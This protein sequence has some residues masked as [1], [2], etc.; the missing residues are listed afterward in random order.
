M[1]A[2]DV[3]RLIEIAKYSLIDIEDPVNIVPVCLILFCLV[4]SGRPR[5]FLSFWAMFNACI[6]HCWMDG[7]IGIFARGP[8]WL[9]EQY[10][11]LDMRYWLTRDPMVMMISAV[12]LVIMGP[13][14]LIWYH[15]L[16]Q[17]RWYSDVV[18]II[19]STFQLMGTILYV[20]G[21]VL[22]NFVH[23]PSD[24]PP[25]F[26]KTKDLFYFWFVFVFCNSVWIFLPITI[27][28]KSFWNIS[29]IYHQQVKQSKPG[30]KKKKASKQD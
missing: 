18:A 16:V 9:V 19:T 28:S 24:W 30:E 29:T 27:I 26:S 6:I 8:K 10:G 22:D 17:R 5:G 21:E 1:A 12:E 13:L 25:S 20:G 7:I 3:D 11:I 2:I 15:S 4:F 23:L 14:C